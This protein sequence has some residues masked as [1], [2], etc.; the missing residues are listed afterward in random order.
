MPTVKELLKKWGFSYTFKSQQG[1]GS[2]TSICYVHHREGHSEYTEFTVPTSFPEYM[3][4]SG[5]QEQGAG[6]TY[7]D[8]YAFKNGL[9]ILT[10]GDDTDAPKYEEEL[11]RPRRPIIPPQEKKA[12]AVPVAHEVKVAESD[13][14]K[15]LRFIEA[16]EVDPKTKTVVKLFSENERIDYQ[17]E[18]K[19]ARDKPEELVKILADIIVTGKKRRA[20]VRG[21]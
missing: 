9:G 11:Q 5:A 8:R 19:E 4:L 18:C 14:D 15:I 7:A 16:T 2:Y 12:D 10:R 13:Y 3:N 17:H 21:E 1:P 20:A 6:C